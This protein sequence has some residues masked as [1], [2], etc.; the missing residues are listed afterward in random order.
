M[1]ERVLPTVRILL[2]CD[3]ANY[4][5]ADQKWMLKNPWGTLQLPPGANFPFRV[6]DM[7]VYTQFV[8]GLGAFDLA[9]ELLRIADDGS[10]KS[11]GTSAATRIEFPT[12]ERL[13]ARDSAFR[14]K[15]VP[16]RQAGLFEFRA[17]AA[18]EGGSEIL[19]G[20]SA[21]LRVLDRRTRL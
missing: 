16:F 11:I 12:G 5:L 13:L 14:L 19:T 1:A 21:E 18:T 7:W 9:V 17:V 6:K 20:Q 4:D 2:P 10:R 8:D 3:S 15:R